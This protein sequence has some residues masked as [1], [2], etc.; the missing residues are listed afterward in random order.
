MKRRESSRG[1]TNYPGWKN[2]P[3]SEFLFFNIFNRRNRYFTM[4][5]LVFQKMIHVWS[6]CH[7]IFI[8]T[9]LANI[10]NA[11]IRIIEINYKH[12]INKA[13]SVNCEHKFR[14]V[15]LWNLFVRQIINKIIQDSYTWIMWPYSWVVNYVHF[16]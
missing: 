13:S 16:C 6:K 2:Y 9:P 3:D 8:F 1:H 14:F 12:S 5:I 15:F 11:G 4:Q 7:S 10:V